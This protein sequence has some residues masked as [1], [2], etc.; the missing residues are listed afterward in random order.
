VLN[1]N[2][3]DKVF[4]DIAFESVLND[5]GEISKSHFAYICTASGELFKVNNSTKILEEIKLIN[6]GGV[7]SIEIS[8]D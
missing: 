3:R 7:T 2:G 5:E 1:S 4:T 6:G 8:N